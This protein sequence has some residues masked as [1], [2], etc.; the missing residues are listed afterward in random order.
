M[1][2]RES[3]I[4]AE[5]HGDLEPRIRFPAQPYG[6][7]LDVMIEIHVAKCLMEGVDIREDAQGDYYTLGVGERPT[8]PPAYILRALDCHTAE[9]IYPEPAS[10]STQASHSSINPR[11]FY[12]QHQLPPEHRTISN[13]DK[14]KVKLKPPH[15]PY[16][17]RTQTPSQKR[18]PTYPVKAPRPQKTHPRYPNQQHPH[19]FNFNTNYHQS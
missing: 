1:E 2:I 17:R 9:Q 8:L 15:H 18:V 7:N 3:G 11:K 4:Q 10:S 12:F 16:Q 5:Q 6:E 13:T 19:D 14:G